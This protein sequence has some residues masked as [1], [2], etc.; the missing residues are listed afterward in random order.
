[1]LS[2]VRLRFE[3]P[4]LVDE[5]IK[6]HWIAFRLNGSYLGST[7]RTSYGLYYHSGEDSVVDELKEQR[8]Y[9]SGLGTPVTSETDF[10]A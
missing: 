10:E 4:V 8:F 3:S 7:K 6:L 2:K 9:T 5:S 1:M